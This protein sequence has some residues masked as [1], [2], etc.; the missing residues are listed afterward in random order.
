M[1]QW[2]ATVSWR[3]KASQD[4]R[5]RIAVSC[6]CCCCCCAVGRGGGSW[7]GCGSATLCPS[8]RLQARAAVHQG[9]RALRRRAFAHGPSSRLHSRPPPR[10]A[11]HA[12]VWAPTLLDR[13]QAA[14]ASGRA[15]GCWRG[16]PRVGRHGQRC[17]AGWM[18]NGD[19]SPPG[20]GRGEVMVVVMGLRRGVVGAAVVQRTVRGGA[21]TTFTRGESHRAS[22]HVSGRAPPPRLARLLCLSS[23]VS[24]LRP[25]L[26]GYAMR[27]A[28]PPPG[29]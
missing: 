10:A 8:L 23:P 7:D 6:C 5:D 9:A 12:W 13:P 18:G 14:A 22:K 3:P 19:L 17:G 25:P 20:A 26:P 28:P 2:G 29:H 15:G 11:C 4:V 21:L 24:A 27:W 1:N 16:V